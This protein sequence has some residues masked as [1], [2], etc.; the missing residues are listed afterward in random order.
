LPLV[1]AAPRTATRALEGPVGR[2]GAEAPAVWRLIERE[3]ALGEPVAGVTRAELVWAVRH[4]GALDAAD[5]LDRRTRIGLVPEDR[6][7]AL[8][9]ARAILDAYG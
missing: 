4:E 9:V 1:G 7:A 6:A 5:L 8:P 2:Y 3:P